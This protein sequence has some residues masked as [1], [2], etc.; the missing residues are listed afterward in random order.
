MKHFCSL[1]INIYIYIYILSKFSLSQSSKLLFKGKLCSD[2]RMY[3]EMFYPGCTIQ[4]VLS[5]LYRLL[6]LMTGW[7]DM[8]LAI[9]RPIYLKWRIFVLLIY[10]YICKYIKFFRIFRDERLP[11]VLFNFINDYR[12]YLFRWNV[13]PLE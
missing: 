1:Y 10:K 7:Y 12:W 3:V 5:R 6:D 11:T 4:V 13:N 2:F 9:D 8:P